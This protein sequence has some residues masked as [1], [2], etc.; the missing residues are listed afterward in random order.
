MLRQNSTKYLN[1]AGL[2][3]SLVLLLSR[4]DRLQKLIFFGEK[5]LFVQCFSLHGSQCIQ[6]LRENWN[7]IRFESLI[8]KNA[9]VFG[10]AEQRQPTSAVIW[11]KGL[12]LLNMSSGKWLFEKILLFQISP[13]NTLN[14]KTPPPRVHTQSDQNILSKF[15]GCSYA[16]Q[17]STGI[18]Y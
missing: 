11:R 9:H 4:Q 7:K 13:N 16:F 6:F 17:L 8:Q 15:L 12:R 1:K 2:N 10:T 14:F 3:S 5:E 18:W